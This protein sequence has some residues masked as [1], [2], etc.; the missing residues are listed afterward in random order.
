VSTF[1]GQDQTTKESD[2]E[3]GLFFYVYTDRLSNFINTSKEE[4]M[5]ILP[6]NVI[7][8]EPWRDAPSAVSG[9]IKSV[10][11]IRKFSEG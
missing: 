4:I 1:P 5:K 2:K 9:N 10:E 8:Y 11:D 7:D 3:D 6:T